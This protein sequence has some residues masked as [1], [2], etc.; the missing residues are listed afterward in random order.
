MKNNSVVIDM[1]Y[2][3][4]C[5]LQLTMQVKDAANGTSAKPKFVFTY[6]TRTKSPRTMKTITTFIDH[7]SEWKKTDT[8]KI[9]EKLTN[10]SALMISHSILTEIG[11][12]L[13]VGVTNTTESAHSIRKNTQNSE[14]SVVTPAQS[15]FIR[16]VDTA[17]LSVPPKSDP[18]LTIYLNDFLRTYKREQQKRRILD[19][20]I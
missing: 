20:D 16:P 8:V 3:L 11:K 10:T 14:F 5:F 9:L 19:S 18:D 2:G 13:V 4:I 12:K 15:I 6:N 7:P 17:I 1:T